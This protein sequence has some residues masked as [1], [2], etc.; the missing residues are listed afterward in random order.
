MTDSGVFH[1][2]HP[3]LHVFEVA[4]VAA[5][6]FRQLREKSP[7]RV[8]QSADQFRLFGGDGAAHAQCVVE[9]AGS[10]A[11][12]PVQGEMAKIIGG[13]A[14]GGEKTDQGADVDDVRTP[15]AAPRQIER[16]R[17]GR[18]GEC[19]EDRQPALQETPFAHGTPASASA[20]IASR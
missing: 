9:G 5:A 16:R 19:G 6:R 7:V 4:F 15:D 2:M 1:L 11:E 13:Q 3:Q 20:G 17:D 10:E 18:G 14:G 8:V 12:F